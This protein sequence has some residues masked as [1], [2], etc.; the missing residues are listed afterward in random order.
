MSIN[1]EE[2]SKDIQRQLDE[3]E[4]ALTL[5]QSK[6]YFKDTVRNMGASKALEQFQSEAARSVMVNPVYRKF[7]K[8]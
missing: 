7:A 4:S 2:I 6:Q 1:D 3:I 5:P 8:S